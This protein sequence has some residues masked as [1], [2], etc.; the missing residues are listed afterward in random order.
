M[1]TLSDY[2]LNRS[3]LADHLGIYRENSLQWLLSAIECF[4]EDCSIKNRPI[5]DYH[6]WL[7]QK[8]TSP[9]FISDG[10]KLGKKR[11]KRKQIKQ[12]LLDRPDKFS[13]VEYYKR[14]TGDRRPPINFS[15]IK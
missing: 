2:P 11:L 15:Y 1:K 3:Q 13:R 14:L 4:L 12:A 9:P 6:L 10:R 8:L 5:D 7:L